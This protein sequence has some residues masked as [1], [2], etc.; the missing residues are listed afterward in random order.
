MGVIHKV[1]VFIEKL[2]VCF[3]NFRIDSFHSFS[4]WLKSEHFKYQ[5]VHDFEVMV[6]LS[7]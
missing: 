5:F 6:R 4:N 2:N 3:V 7:F 1:L